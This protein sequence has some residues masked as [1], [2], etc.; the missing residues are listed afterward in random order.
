MLALQR[1]LLLLN[2]VLP[3]SHLQAVADVV[4]L[5]WVDTLTLVHEMHLHVAAC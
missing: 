1:H 5:F 4:L 2:S 3:E